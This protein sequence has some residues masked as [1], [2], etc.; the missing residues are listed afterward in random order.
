MD[1]FGWLKDSLHQIIVGALIAVIGALTYT[2]WTLAN[3]YADRVEEL[4]KRVDGHE[5]RLN[6]LDST[7]AQR[8]ARAVEEE[9]TGVK[10]DA[11][12]KAIKELL[13]KCC[14]G[15]AATCSSLP[16]S[17]KANF[18]LLYENARLNEGQ[19]LTKESVGIRL[20]KGHESQ[21]TG[22]VNAFSA[23]APSARVVKFEVTGYSSTAEFQEETN[24]GSRQ[25]M[26]DSNELNV[27]AA[28]LRTKLVVDYLKGQNAAFE[29][30]PKPRVP[31][32]SYDDINRPYLDDSDI[33]SGTAQEALNRT[34]L[35]SVVDAGACDRRRQT[36]SPAKS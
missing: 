25:P 17:A 34:V 14:C 3:K 1:F 20:T 5:R 22:I 21:L 7:I 8:V 12:D 28:N 4:S 15:S 23:C 26:S 13:G 31:L 16:T 6:E 19:K 36:E 30:E 24:D 10:I 27:E 11:I 18:T 2:N 32:E 29:V 9:L 35:I 33:F